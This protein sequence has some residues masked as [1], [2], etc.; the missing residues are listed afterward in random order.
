MPSLGKLIESF[1]SLWP[2]SGAE[3]W[4][5]PG[6]V[7]GSPNQQISRVLLTVDVTDE[8]VESA[9]EAG[10]QLLLAHHPFLMRGVKSVAETGAKG[11]TVSKAI[12]ANLAIY[13]AHT[14]ADIVESG[15][16]DVLAQQLGV[17]NFRA[18]VPAGSN[19]GTGRIGTLE[20][21]ITLG[22]F[23]ARVARVLPHTA[24]GV[25]VAGDYQQVI[26]RVALCGGAGDAFIADAQSQGANVYLSSDLR[27][28]VV[29]DARETAR[30]QNQMAIIDTSHW[31]SEFLW[32]EVAAEQLRRIH[33]DTAFEVCDIRT[34]PWDFVITQ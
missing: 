23:A 11:S 34:D 30:L 20:D 14:N 31:A 19:V 26:E 28:H 22:E 17:Q 32:L 12:K 10:F 8:V 21:P 15:V 24:G 5:A 3:E 13:A 7:T 25:R 18:L 4:D 1:E 16:S 27:H 29:Q 2:I 33:S 6:L 9:I